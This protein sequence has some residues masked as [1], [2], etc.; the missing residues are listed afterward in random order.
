METIALNL[1]KTIAEYTI[2][3]AILIVII[4]YLY[5]KSKKQEK[6]IAEYIKEI[7]EVEKD[8]LKLLNKTLAMFDKF[9]FKMENIT[10]K[11]NNKDENES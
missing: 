3:F 4:I 6:E 11:L 2:V 8:N 7:R 1:L 5:I 9:G 10:K